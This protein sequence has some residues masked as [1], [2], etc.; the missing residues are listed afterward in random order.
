MLDTRGTRPTKPSADDPR[1]RFVWLGIDLKAG[2]IG[3]TADVMRSVIACF[4]FIS[5]IIAS[6]G[7]SAASSLSEQLSVPLET[8]SQWKYEIEDKVLTTKL[9]IAKLKDTTDPRPGYDGA[10][11][12]AVL[13][14]LYSGVYASVNALIDRMVF[15]IEQNR[16][17]ISTENYRSSILDCQRNIDALLQYEKQLLV[18]GFA[19]G[20]PIMALEYIGYLGAMVGISDVLSRT[21]P[22]LFGA[23]QKQVQSVIAELRKRKLRPF[24]ELTLENVIIDTPQ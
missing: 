6:G 18:S 22:E 21:L 23:D 13:R 4:F 20:L 7:Y 14:F 24:D 3:V 1:G 16:G 15:D 17:K 12:E 8:F 11:T 9:N 19:A 2:W 5:A 10:S